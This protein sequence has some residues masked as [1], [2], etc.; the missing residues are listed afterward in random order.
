[1]PLNRNGKVDRRALPA[2]DLSAVVAA[3][4]HRAPRDPVET[5]INEIWTALLG[6]D[7]GIHGNFFQMGGN[8]LLAVRLIARIQD[9]FDVDLPVRAV[10]QGPT[11]AEQAAAVEEQIRAEIAAMSDAELVADATQLK[12]YES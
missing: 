1:M 7:A 12:G 11:V 6:V 3:A 5:R 2:P 8:S 9:E 10:F 4:G